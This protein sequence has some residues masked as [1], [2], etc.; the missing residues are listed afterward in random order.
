MTRTQAPTAPIRSG[1]LTL[2]LSSLKTLRLSS[3]PFK[4]LPARFRRWPGLRL[5][6]IMSRRIPG[7]GSG[8]GTQSESDR[9]HQQRGH[10]VHLHGV[11][12]AFCHLQLLDRVGELHRNL[13]PVAQRPAVPRDSSATTG[14]EDPADSAG[15]P[16]GRLQECAGPLDAYRQL[17]GTS[18]EK[19]IGDLARPTAL[20]QLLG[21]FRGL[22]PLP[23]EVFTEAA[24]GR[25]EV[26]RRPPGPR[27][28]RGRGWGFL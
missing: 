28:P 7:S 19:P 23:L 12:D 1:S 14:D 20:E 2:A 6:V 16:A 24:G 5:T 22:T 10:F 26:P 11:E 21:L 17:L 18:L 8:C 13:E 4:G 9:Q 15:R 27:P 3:S 25:R